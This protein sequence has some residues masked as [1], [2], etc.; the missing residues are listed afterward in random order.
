MRNILLT[1]ALICAVGVASGQ[2]HPTAQ[3]CGDP[4]QWTEQMYEAYTYR[5][6]TDYAAFSEP[7]KLGEVD[8][9]LLEAALFYETNRQRAAHQLPELRY[10]RD[11]NVCAHNY[12]VSMV[13]NDFFAHESPIAGEETMVERLAAVGYPN[14]SCAENLALCAMKATYA[15]T[16]RYIVEEKW[17]KSKG[18]RANILRKGL[19]H[20]GCGAAFYAD[21]RVVYVKATQNF[22]KKL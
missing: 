10:D 20:L 21:G 11:L 13:E 4:E 5:N 19:T 22:L 12:S 9:G 7:V 2:M 1:I 17:M 16:A 15:E 8:A 14:S 6:Y 18:H 3:A